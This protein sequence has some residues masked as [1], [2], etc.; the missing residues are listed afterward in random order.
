MHVYTMVLDDGES[1]KI[2]SRVVGPLL[3][4][5]SL[6]CCQSHEKV[7]GEIPRQI[8]RHYIRQTIINLLICYVMGVQC[9]YYKLFLCHMVAGWEIISAGVVHVAAAQFLFNFTSQNHNFHLKNH[10]MSSCTM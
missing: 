3:F 10:I 4:Q 5:E 8:L 2:P 9:S 7:F 1:N 6:I